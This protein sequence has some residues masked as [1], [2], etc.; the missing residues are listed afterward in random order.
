VN[1][2]RVV[3]NV[4][5]L[6]CG[7][8]CDDLT[9]RVDGNRI[10]DVAPA[11]PVGRAWFGDGQ[12]PNR[13]LSQ[14]REIT[15]EQALEQLADAL[16]QAKGSCLVYLGAD[17]TTQSQRAALLV[18]DLLHATLD[19][20][21]SE[22]AAQGLL[23]AQRRGRAGSTLGEVRNRGDV[24]LFWGIDPRERYP[25]FLSRYS[26]EPVGT[27]VPEGRRGRFVISVTIGGDKGLQPSDFSLE[28][29]PEQETGA[30]SLLRAAVLDRQPAESALTQQM[31][32]IARKLAAARYAVLVHDGEPS[33]EGRNP[34][35]VEALIALAQAL[36]GPARAALVSLRAGGNRVGAESALTWQTGYP[37]S[38]DYSPG[39]PRYRP[40]QRGLAGLVR[41]KFR[42]AL[43]V[44]KPPDNEGSGVFSRIRPGV[45]GPH[46]SQSAFASIAI[47]TGVAGIHEEGTAYRMDEVPLTLRP[48]L[49]GP[50]STRDV[51]MSLAEAIRNRL[52]S[53]SE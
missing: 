34:L 27:Q 46:A 22:T 4:T 39:Y 5:C 9:V 50:R 41:G 13:I 36:N 31:T 51:L 25:R 6:G 20:E 43:V 11:C 8:G 28:L 21:T 3:E 38:V 44:G 45:I 18:A 52:R 49:Q 12:V 30:L 7:C 24:F 15:L 42:A 35:R 32:Q 48:A 29:A 33:A 37:F 19:S 2:E 17:L 40:D 16:V 23:T 26:L 14:G 1:G 53:S 10:V 47:D